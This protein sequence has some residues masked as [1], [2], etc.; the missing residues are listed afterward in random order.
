MRI[1][2]SFIINRDKI[3]QIEGG[4]VLVNGKQI[5]ISKTYQDQLF[6]SLNFL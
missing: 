1:H 2:R 5:P 6:E 4:N 3:Q